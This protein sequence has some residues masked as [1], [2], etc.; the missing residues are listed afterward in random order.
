MPV[1]CSSYSTPGRRTRQPGSASWLPTQ[2][3]CT[4]LL[5]TRSVNARG[6]RLGKIAGSDCPVGNRR[7]RR[8]CRL[9]THPAPI[10]AAKFS[11]FSLRRYRTRLR[12]SFRRCRA[13][14]VM[15]DWPVRRDC[16]AE[17]RGRRR[18]PQSHALVGP[19][20]ERFDGG[21]VDALGLKSPAEP[22]IACQHRCGVHVAHAGDL[23]LEK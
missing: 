10:F 5:P 9:H 15:A 19:E 8:I 4:D 1:F 2:R 13:F 20:I 3:S 23:R 14:A 7:R 16:A 22:R 21:K 11:K 12:A 6:G 18:R 17:R